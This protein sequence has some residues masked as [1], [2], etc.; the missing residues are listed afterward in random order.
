M[1]ALF[2]WD[3]GVLMSKLEGVIEGIIAAKEIIGGISDFFSTSI[4]QG[5][6]GCLDELTFL[7]NKLLG[8]DLTAGIIDSTKGLSECISDLCVVVLFCIL[9]FYGFCSLF[10]YFFSKQI[11]IPWKM[12]IRLV[13][14]FALSNMA[15]LICYTTI[16]FTENITEYVI[17][18]CDEEISFSMF[19]VNQYDLELN[20][21]V[22]EI[23]I[24]SM[25]DLFKISSYILIFIVAVAM[26]CRFILI[27]IIIIFSPILFI[28]GGLK[29]TEKIFFKSSILFLKLLG[30][31]VIV[32]I[33]LAIFINLNFDETIILQVFFVSTLFLF[34]K[35]MKKIY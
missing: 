22:E 35:F 5:F 21:K 11:E 34:I 13:V 29:I 31:Q 8:L 3:G 28:F 17:S 9:L 6:Y 32:A 20:E 23:D 27:K 30:C 18:S 26:G 15:V 10:Q 24:F 14:F 12:F 4:S 16:F 2:F 19:E 7:T 33:T 1:M 25:E